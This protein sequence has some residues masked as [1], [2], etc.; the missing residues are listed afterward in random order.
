MRNAWLWYAFIV[1]VVILSGCNPSIS[2]TTKSV[3]VKSG[4]EVVIGSVDIKTSSSDIQITGCSVSYDEKIFSSVKIKDIDSGNTFDLKNNKIS[5]NIKKKSNKAF[6]IIAVI[7]ASLK[8]QMANITLGNFSYK[9]LPWGKSG[10][11]SNQFVFNVQIEKEPPLILDFLSSVINPSISINNNGEAIA[12]WTIEGDNKLIIKNIDGKKKNSTGYEFSGTNIQEVNVFIDD[13]GKAVV[14]YIDKSNTNK[15]VIYCWDGDNWL[16]K[17]EL[18]L[19]NSVN[20][21]S[22]TGNSSGQLV[23]AI[24]YRSTLK[25]VFALRMNTDGELLDESPVNIGED[26][27]GKPSLSVNKYGD[28]TVAWK[29]NTNHT[30]QINRYSTYGNCWLSTPELFP[31]DGSLSPQDPSICADEDG[32]FHLGWVEW[33]SGNKLNPIIK[34]CAFDGAWNDI[35]RIYLPV[36]DNTIDSFSLGCNSVGYLGAIFKYNIMNKISD[37]I[38]INKMDVWSQPSSILTVDSN[39]ASLPL[40]L[41]G[42]DSG[43]FM[44]FHTTKNNVSM[45]KNASMNQWSSEVLFD[46]NNLNG[47]FNYGNNISSSRNGNAAVIWSTG[48]GPDSKAYICIYR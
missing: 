21:F 4:S 37:V 42:N 40:K 13:N 19:N 28:I 18:T 6:E 22:M 46:A 29:Y 33:A 12:A 23:L 17:H 7:N 1:M 10:T 25:K 39:I 48:Q 35:E 15:I 43:E 38:F 27:T 20:E 5:L 30:I 31:R 3:I 9:A 47:H 34:I 16:K 2:G 36:T 32:T 26:I 45:L 8:S 14:A 11:I 44:M 41:L 24:T